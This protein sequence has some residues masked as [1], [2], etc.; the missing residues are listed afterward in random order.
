MNETEGQTPRIGMEV[1]VWHSKARFE[2]I[3]QALGIPSR[4]KWSVGDH[5]TNNSLPHWESYFRSSVRYIRLPLREGLSEIVLR[6]K[7][8]TRS[9]WYGE[10]DGRIAL[11]FYLDDKI[12][13][14]SFSPEII[15][16]LSEL[17]AAIVIR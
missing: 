15:H 4:M 5:N 2:Q 9:L 16:D 12:H 14:I 3:E 17:G 11:Y 8:L 13:E 6:L 7:L 10:G 1:A